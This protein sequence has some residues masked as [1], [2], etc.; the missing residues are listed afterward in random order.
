MFCLACISHQSRSLLSLWWYHVLGLGH[1]Y[2]MLQCHASRLL[3]MNDFESSARIPYVSRYCSLVNLH[4][5]AEDYISQ[6]PS[7]GLPC[8]VWNYWVKLLTVAITSQL[9]I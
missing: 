5:R 8:H 7:R 6:L 3:A 2:L 4:K 9:T 1:E